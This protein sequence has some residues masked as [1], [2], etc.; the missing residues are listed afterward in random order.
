MGVPLPDVEGGPESAA[1]APWSGVLAPLAAALAPFRALP[2]LQ[3]QQKLLS[4]IVESLVMAPGSG[5]KLCAP[6]RSTIMFGRL[7][8]IVA[9]LTAVLAPVRPCYA[10][11]YS[12]SQTD[13]CT[14]QGSTPKVGPAAP[15]LDS[16][17]TRDDGNVDSSIA[18]LCVGMPYCVPWL[19]ATCSQLAFT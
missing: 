15:R 13:L 1:A 3:T 7:L 12:M 19:A 11:K 8:H 4:S 17:V 18:Q 9:S 6:F 5:F 14:L 16:S 10:C 2:C